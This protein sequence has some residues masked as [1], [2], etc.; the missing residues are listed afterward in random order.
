MKVDHTRDMVRLSML[1]SCGDSAEDSSSSC[2]GSSSGHL[3]E[4]HGEDDVEDAGPHTPSIPAEVSS[5]GYDRV[6]ELGPRE[7]GSFVITT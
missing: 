4:E 1:D 3:Q 6:A 5:A 2:L 7:F